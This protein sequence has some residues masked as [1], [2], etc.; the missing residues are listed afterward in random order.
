[1]TYRFLR[2]VFIFFAAAAISVSFSS[3]ASAALGAKTATQ[4]LVL[5]HY[6]PWY[7]VPPVSRQ[8]NHWNLRN[9]GSEVPGNPF[10]LEKTSNGKAQIG[11]RFY[12]LTGPYDSRNPVVLEYHAALMKLAGIDGVIFDWYGIRDSD[13]YFDYVSIHQGVLEMVKVIRKAGLKFAVCY[14]DQ[15]IKHM[16]EEGKL[17]ASEAIGV[18]REAIAWL[19][20]NFFDDPAY[21]KTED[22]RPVLFCF[23]P[24][25]FPEAGQWNSIFSGI[26]PRPYFVDWMS[27]PGE[28]FRGNDGADA[29]FFWPDMPDDGELT[30]AKLVEGLSW[31]YG[32]F[33]DSPYIV[34]GVSPSFGDAVLKEAKMQTNSRFLTYDD[35]GTFSLM[36]ETAESWQPDVIQLITWND[37]GESTIIEPTVERGYAELEYVQRWRKKTDA[38]FPA[39]TPEDL[40][41]PLEFFK[42]MAGK[43]ATPAQAGLIEAAYGAI[44]S[45]NPVAFRDCAAQAGVEYDLSVQPNLRETVTLPGALTGGSV[46]ADGAPAAAG[47]NVSITVTANSGYAL[48]AIDVFETG[49]ESVKVNLSDDNGN[50]TFTMPSFAV[51]VRASF[52]SGAQEPGGDDDNNDDDNND[53][54]EDKPGAGGGGC[55]AGGAGSLILAAAAVVISIRMFRRV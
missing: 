18:A 25:Y 10:D 42:L 23:G 17:T 47:E 39:F 50:F 52:K 51:T 22:G 40:R 13:G 5:A 14:E 11:S 15:T 46:R 19:D 41:A 6:M 43:T 20:A 29:S 53:D 2:Q 1:M 44:F 30:R 48:E 35:G 49:N 31:F 8:F 37:Y 38:A 24:Q 26:S 36:F 27:A 9:E 7:Q 21:V 34:A 54:N 3:A 55:N 4:P 12:P 33:K 28:G 16:I 32:V 45:G